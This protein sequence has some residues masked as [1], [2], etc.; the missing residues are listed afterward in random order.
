M[1]DVCF[2]KPTK[3]RKKERKKEGLKKRGK[4]TWSSFV[5]CLN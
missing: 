3:E 5:N 4:E 2:S 1:Q